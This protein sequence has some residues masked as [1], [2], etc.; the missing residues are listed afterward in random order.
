VK[1]FMIRLY[2]GSTLVFLFFSTC[3]N[4]SAPVL[5]LQDALE[6]ADSYSPAVKA[7]LSRESQAQS[8]VGIS[9]SYY[10]P[11]VSV[12]AIDS[13]GFPGSTAAL[14]LSGL[15][16]SPF[17]SGFSAGA[18][19]TQNIFDFGRT[20]Y[21]VQA[22]KYDAETQQ[23]STQ[24]NRY[25][26]EQGLITAFMD[27]ALNRAQESTWQELSQDTSLVVR[28]VERFVNT[29]Q[30]SIVDRYLA[31]AQQEQAKTNTLDFQTRS[32]V[33]QSRV[34]LI[35]GIRTPF[36]CPDLNENSNELSLKSPTEKESPFI[37]FAKTRLSAS[38][39]RLEQTKA[40]NLPQLVG[41]ASAG[42]LQGTHLVDSQN[43]SLGIGIVLPIFEGFRIKDETD[44]KAAQVEER[45]YEVQSSQLGL[46]NLN[47]QYEE[48]I[49]SAKVRVENLVIELDN[50]NTAFAVA[51]KRYFGF[52]GTLVDVRDSLTNLARVEGDL[53]TA[54]ATFFEAQFLKSILNHQN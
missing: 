22:A 46:E 2:Q 49:Q 15:P 25:Q 16:A 14:G 1:I 7:A 26:T 23:H 40:Q 28:E 44:Q 17:R 34:A 42:Y 13:T 41:I 47:Q 32:S 19:L 43:Y 11:D 33:S 54:R 29:G 6:K 39:S 36:A 12:E 52:Q 45:D 31:R 20:Y 27:C 53:N 5:S 3:V 30:R 38:Q 10:L 35:T 48:K 8:R 18:V 24:I 9:E 21:G 51:K 4:A 37:L 50:A